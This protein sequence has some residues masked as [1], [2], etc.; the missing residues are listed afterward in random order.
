[1]NDCRTFLDA[2][3]AAGLTAA[4]GADTSLADR[5]IADGEHAA[6][7]IHAVCDRVF[8]TR[9]DEAAGLALVRALI[10]AG[11]DLGHRHAANGDGLVTTAISL[12]VPSIAHALISAGAPAGRKGLF[13]ALPLHWAA[14]MGA[15]DLTARLIEGADLSARDD[16]FDSTPLGWAMQGWADPPKGSLGGQIA[17]VRLLVSAGA[18]IEPK[19]LESDRVKADPPLHAA[20]RL[21]A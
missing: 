16:A 6:H 13:G 17:C 5:L 21:G 1:M 2:G 3:D 4:L 12:A 7:P 14:M 9:L 11:A 8:D 15:P 19:W 20:L 10:G 18:A